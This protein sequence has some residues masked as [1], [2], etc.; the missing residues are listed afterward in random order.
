MKKIGLTGGIGSGKTIVSRIFEQ[1]GV[2]VFNAD[3]EARI[4]LDSDNNVRKKIS[5]AFGADVLDSSGK[6]DRKKI[7][8]IVFSDQNALTK[9]N[10]IIH[11]ALINKFDEW[12][13][14][15]EKKG[16]KIII[17]EAAILFESGSYRFMDKII[18]VYAPEEL[19]IS[20]TMKRDA[21]T[22]NEVRARIANQL[23]EEA[24]LKRAD[25]VIYNDDT[26]PV[27]PQVLSIFHSIS[28]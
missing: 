18:L 3:S 22:E 23:S 20:R 10:G 4:L 19:R 24:K 5:S 27:I 2:P 15:H 25:F 16:S 17:E 8:S 9:L 1:L 14:E 7:A 12:R 6:P 28:V 21:V 26:K 13:I 11:P